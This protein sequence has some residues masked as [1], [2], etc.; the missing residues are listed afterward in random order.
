[1]FI[2][3][4]GAC[5][6]VYVQRTAYTSQFSPSTRGFQGWTQIVRLMDS[7]FTFGA[8]SSA[9][10]LAASYLPGN[11]VLNRIGRDGLQVPIC[12][13]VVISILVWSTF[14]YTCLS[15]V[16]LLSYYFILLRQ[17]HA[18]RANLE[19]TT[20]PR[21]TLNFWPSSVAKCWPDRC[22]PSVLGL[23]GA[24]NQTQGFVHAR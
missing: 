5:A 17:C 23:C 21:M 15:V 19:F 2:G 11:S 16:Y 3:Q 6:M 12:K 20:E 1:M 8:I 13:S 9:P 14:S 22:A 24:G 18:G 4:S 10:G 7:T